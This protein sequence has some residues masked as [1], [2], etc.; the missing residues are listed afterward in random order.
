MSRRTSVSPLVCVSC[1]APVPVEYSTGTC[2]YCGSSFA[3]D[4]PSRPR[5][6]QAPQPEPEP[7][8]LTLETADD[9]LGHAAGVVVQRGRGSVSD[10]M[11]ALSVGYTRAARLVDQLEEAGVV[12]PFEGSAA[13][14]VLAPTAAEANR[15]LAAIPQS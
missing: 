4:G 3:I 6:K 13:R 1:G 7:D 9:L 11:R 12:G 10:V 14:R 5:R 8:R 2:A 15:L